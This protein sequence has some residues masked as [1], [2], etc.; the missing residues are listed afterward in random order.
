MVRGFTP[1]LPSIL[2]RPRFEMGLPCEY[3]GQGRSSNSVSTL[4]MRL[5][6]SR[7]VAWSSKSCRRSAKSIVPMDSLLRLPERMQAAFR[8]LS[9]HSMPAK[10]AI[11]SS[12]RQLSA[13]RLLNPSGDFRIGPS[14]SVGPFRC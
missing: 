8:A 6:A 7:S 1:Y 2:A 11:A 13:S 10:S 14:E 9:G 5:E 4:T 12:G 3:S